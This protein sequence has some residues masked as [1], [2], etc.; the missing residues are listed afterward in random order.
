MNELAAC[1]LDS[2]VVELLVWVQ[3]LGVRTERQDGARREAQAGRQCRQRGGG[4]ASQVN[5][6]TKT[7][8]L[9]I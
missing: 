3:L 4:G 5:L 1:G 9:S 8:L 2:F 6:G 7:N